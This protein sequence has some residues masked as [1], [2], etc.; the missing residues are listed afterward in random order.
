MSN[1]PEQR[2]ENLKFSF[3]MLEIFQASDVTHATAHST[4]MHELANLFD[5]LACVV[6]LHINKQAVLLMPLLLKLSRS[7]DGKTSQLVFPQLF[8]KQSTYFL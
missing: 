6:D 1:S 3:Q 7:T 5:L 8:F 2:C 4:I